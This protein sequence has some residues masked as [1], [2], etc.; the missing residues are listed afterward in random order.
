[1]LNRGVTRTSSGTIKSRFHGLNCI[2]RTF[3]SCFTV[4]IDL[5]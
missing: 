2:P 4:D 3:P 1:M 5:T